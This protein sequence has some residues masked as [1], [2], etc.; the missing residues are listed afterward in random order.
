MHALEFWR[1]LALLHSGWV[2]GSLQGATR[3]ASRTLLS[4]S[5]SLRSKLLTDTIK[6]S[7]LNA[8][9]PLRPPS[10]AANA[11]KWLKG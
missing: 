5:P 11:D 9:A 3:H 7:K 4:P 6:H 1:W 2:I 8:N 10:R